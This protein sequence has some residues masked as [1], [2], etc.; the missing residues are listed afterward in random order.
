MTGSA[1]ASPPSEDALGWL[2]I[3]LIPR[4]SRQHLHTLARRF[5]SA[6]YVF[7]AEPQQIA[8]LKGFDLQLAQSILRA[9][10]AGNDDVD[11]ELER[12]ERL[13]VHLYSEEDPLYPLNLRQ[14]ASPPPLLYV[15][16]TLDPERNSCALAVIGAR[17]ATRY[18]IN[19]AQQLVKQ[20]A[21][22]GLTIVSG[23]AI[24]IDSVA[25]RATL[26][27]NGSTIAVLGT[28][29]GRCYPATNKNLAE[30][31]IAKNGALVSEY[32]METG[33]F[34]FNFPE[35]NE[36]IAGLALGLLVVE[37]KRKS[38]TTITSAA[39]LNENRILF[40]VPGDITRENSQGTND[41]IANGARLVQ[42]ANDIFEELAEP[43]ERIL[44]REKSEDTD[45]TTPDA[46]TAEV[47]KTTMSPTEKTI[48][49]IIRHEPCHIDALRLRAAEKGVRVTSGTLIDM[50]LR[51]LILQM[52]GKIYTT[53][54]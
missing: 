30:Q 27:A 34:A 36:V 4:V 43:I 20:V 1:L 54:I 31:I 11:K 47:V 6:A 53:K 48:F 21:A 45:D 18:G 22:R 51:G 23:L 2:R 39:A 52:P 49:D 42:S 24:G 33:S 5:G 50:E 15:R 9:G 29:L 19:V 41:L 3:R 8:A 38:G 40:A 32:P 46:Q 10:F 17:Q 12:M 13:D 28:G 16:G 25:H 37:A 26:E 35:R 44:P 7:A 14:M